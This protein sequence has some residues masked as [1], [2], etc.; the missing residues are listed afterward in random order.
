MSE[1]FF[2]FLGGFTLMSLGALIALSVTSG[3][4]YNKGHQN[5]MQEAFHLGKAV[6]CLGKEGYYWECKND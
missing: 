3:T 1:A 6:Q 4:F 2:M 5:A